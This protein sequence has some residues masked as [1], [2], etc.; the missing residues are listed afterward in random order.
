MRMK[1]VIAVLV[2]LVFALS[3]VSVGFA[4]EVKGTVTKIDGKKITVKDAQGK[5]TTVE[6]KDTAGVKVGDTV[7]IK[8]GVV[9]KMP[10]PA[11]GGY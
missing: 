8:D 6:V 3:I 10:K 7:M 2:A 11:A 5:E 4:A 9:K 1:T